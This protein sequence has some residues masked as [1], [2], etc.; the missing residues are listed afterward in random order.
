MV[1]RELT[2]NEYYRL[3]RQLEAATKELEASDHQ[4][5]TTFELRSQ[6]KMARLVEQE[7]S[8]RELLAKADFTGLHKLHNID[9]KIEAGVRLGEIAEQKNALAS[10]TN[11]KARYTVG[12]RNIINRYT[13]N[14]ERAKAS[15]DRKPVRRAKR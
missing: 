7:N 12:R 5:A 13:R 11:R 4:A 14:A 8:I 2:S 3:K 9:N 1:R 15:L 6:E 10:R